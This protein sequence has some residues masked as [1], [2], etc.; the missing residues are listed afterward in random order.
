MPTSYTAVDEALIPTGEVRPVK[1]TPFD[2]TS[3]PRSASA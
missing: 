1:A 3:P 2:F